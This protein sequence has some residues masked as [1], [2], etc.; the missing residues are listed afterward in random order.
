MALKNCYKLLN[1]WKYLEKLMN[2]FCGKFEGS[3]PEI[4]HKDA[5]SSCWFLCLC[6]LVTVN[7]EWVSIWVNF[8][9][10][11]KMKNVLRKKVLDMGH[12]NAVLCKKWKQGATAYECMPALLG[13][14][15]YCFL[16]L[17]IKCWSIAFINRLYHL[18]FST[19]RLTTVLS[20]SK[21][22]LQC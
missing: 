11:R 18:V 8:P 20:N 15:Y 22:H 21:S 14:F 19:R 7:I 2:N 17:F 10:H 4:Y 3:K 16:H 12:K 9:H 5:S 6:I 13:A 1:S